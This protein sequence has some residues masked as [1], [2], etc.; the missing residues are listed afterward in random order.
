MLGD[1]GSGPSEEEDRLWKKYRLIKLG[2]LS[3][4][5]L[6]EFMDFFFQH[7]WPL[8]PMIPVFYTRRSSYILLVTEEPV[9]TNAIVTIA[10]RY[11]SLSGSHGAIRSERIH[12]HAWRLLQQNLQA[13]MWGATYTRSLGTITSM[14]LLTEWHSKAVNYS[15]ALAHADEEID[16]AYRPLHAQQSSEPSPMSVTHLT[17]KQRHGMMSLLESLNIVTPAYR[18]NKM[19]W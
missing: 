3:T 7:L 15:D 18:S 16:D 19:S 8:R 5:E 10:S 11:H 14:L 17:S 12:W 4:T 1:P 9:L 2:V 13:S 6:I